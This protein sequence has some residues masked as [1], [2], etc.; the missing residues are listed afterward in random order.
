ML[1]SNI[2]NKNG[3]LKWNEYTSKIAYMPSAFKRFLLRKNGG[4]KW[5][6]TI[7]LP[8]ISTSGE[9]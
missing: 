4:L 3:G 7:D 6:R 8:L 5:T 2:K 9:P 1:N